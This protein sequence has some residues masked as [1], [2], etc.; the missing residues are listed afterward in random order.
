VQYF[1]MFGSRAIV[2]GNW[3]AVCKHM[4][5]A[6]FD[7]EQWE[8]YDLGTD[9]SECTDLAAAQPERLSRLISLWWAE[10]EKHGVLPLDDRT[11]ELFGARF[12]PNSP[13]SV[14]RRYV[15]RPP[16]SPLPGQAAA[17]I[18]GRSFDLS[19][20]VTRSAG[21]DG[22]LFATGNENSGIAVFVQNDRLL[23]DYNAFGDHSIVE[24]AVDVPDGDSTL[25]VRLR[26]G[27]GR[28]GSISLEIN[29]QPA[30]TVGVPLIM[31]MISSVGSSVGYNHGSAVSERYL[32]PFP[33][34]G[35]LHELTVQL[36]DDQDP[37]ARH[38][39]AAAEMSRQ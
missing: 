31:M 21:Q 30:G 38:A 32:A 35:K 29:R 14:D 3:K 4:P 6:D 23:V 37:A 2:A 16:M 7:T 15:Y 13:H 34:T 10:A 5:G 24:S 39:E 28:A 18:G 1:E 11:I 36:L 22:V 19:A 17:A 27:A 8:L 9:W 20:H 26:Q 12:R 33:F 25:L